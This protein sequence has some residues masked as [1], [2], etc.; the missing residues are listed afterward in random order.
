MINIKQKIIAT[1]SSALA[2]ALIHFTLNIVQWFI[3]RLGA[4]FSG[5]EGDIVYNT[6]N[7][8]A[9]SEEWTLM[10]VLWI[11]LAPWLGLFFIYSGVNWRRK[12]PTSIKT[13][14]QLVQSWAFALLL[15]QVFFMPLVD[16]LTK[17][18]VYHALNWLHIDYFIQIV[19]GIMMWL[20]FIFKVTNVSALFSTILDLP[21]KKPIKPKQ[22]LFQLPA[23]WYIPIL[24]LTFVVYLSSNYSLP[25][26]FHYYLY[27]LIFIVIVNTLVISRYDVIVK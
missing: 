10:Q 26:N 13:T 5:F 16:I 18:G 24:F 6:F 23:I 9:W 15:L 20:Y 4:S 7:S 27:G 22:I 19:V 2:L 8:M 12:Y 1:I 25:T 3:M 14:L 17:K 21:K 11:Y